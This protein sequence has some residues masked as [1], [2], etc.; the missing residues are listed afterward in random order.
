MILFLLGRSPTWPG[1]AALV[2]TV[3]RTGDA[4]RTRLREAVLK[5]EA[6]VLPQQRA[7]GA[8]REKAEAA[9]AQITELGLPINGAALRDLADELVLAEHHR[10]VEEDWSGRHGDLRSDV[11]HASEAL[12]EAIGRAGIV[13]TTDV[14]KTFQE[15]EGACQWRAEQAAR[16]ETRESLKQQLSDRKAAEKAVDEALAQR[17][18]ADREVM[19]VL[20][21]CGL[22]APDPES[23]SQQLSGWQAKRRERLE[24]FGGATRECAEL[25]ELLAGGTLEDLEARASDHQRQAA[26]LAAELGP[27]PE[28]PANVN[29]DQEVDYGACRCC[30]RAVVRG[31]SIC[32]GFPASAILSN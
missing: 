19:T 21:R 14:D 9:R 12:A 20:A 32:A 17:L 6:Q 4:S 18:S 31:N 16:A 8:A 24:K 27:L 15:Y 30:F 11:A 7:V 26:E 5:L 2:W 25:G 10:Q 23:G 28:M 22:V 29:L 3:F 13:A 1:V